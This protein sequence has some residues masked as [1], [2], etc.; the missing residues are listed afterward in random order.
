MI[1]LFTLLLTAWS[2]AAP[3][4]KPDVEQIDKQRF[5]QHSKSLKQYAAQ[6]QACCGYG[7][8]VD[9]SKPSWENRFFVVDL[10][11]DSVVIE[12]LCAH[13][14]GKTYNGENVVF[15]NEVGSLCSSE[16]RYKIGAK[17]YGNFGMSYR[18]HGLDATNNKALERAVVFHSMS[19]IPDQEG[20]PI[21]MSNGC[22]MVS[23]AILKQTAALIDKT[24]EPLLM[25]IY[26]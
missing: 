16:G 9:M 2:C 8:L 21:C 17:Y 25:W 5:L 15:S 7:I 14:G 12:G 10:Q 19:C 6:Q 11:N 18:L 24:Q 26:K 13:G 3:D 22:P 1:T 4:N 20:E 23:P